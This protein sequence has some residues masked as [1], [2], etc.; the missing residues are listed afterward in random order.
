MCTAQWHHDPATPLNSFTCSILA[1]ALGTQQVKLRGD[2]RGVASRTELVMSTT[3]RYHEPAITQ[4]RKIIPQQCHILMAQSFC[5]PCAWQAEQPIYGLAL[6]KLQ[7]YGALGM[8]RTVVPMRISWGRHR[9]GSAP[10]FISGI[11]LPI[12][13][14]HLIR[15]WFIYLSS[16]VS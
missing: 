2:R 14:G 8:K 5:E 13:L 10:M 1:V 3:Q 6:M 9:R 12:H 16:L 4:H 11:G 15:N 7:R